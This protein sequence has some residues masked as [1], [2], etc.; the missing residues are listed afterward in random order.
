MKKAH[1]E[2][3]KCDVEARQSFL[4]LTRLRTLHFEETQNAPEVSFPLNYQ[5]SNADMDPS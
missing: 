3:L 1:V 4:R 5:N 2:K